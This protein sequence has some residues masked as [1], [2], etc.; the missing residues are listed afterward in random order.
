LPPAHADS[1][2]LIQN[3]GTG[4]QT[5]TGG[6][7]LLNSGLG[8]VAVTTP[9]NQTITANSGGV[10][11][12]TS[13]SGSTSVTAGGS[14]TIRAEFVEVLTG[15]GS[16][17]D[18]TLSA[19]GDQY[20]RTTN[21]NANGESLVVAALGS[22]TAKIESGASQLLEIGYPTMMQGFAGSGV[23]AI[24][25]ANGVDAAGNSL[26]QAVDQNVFSGSILVQ[27]PSGAGATSK[28]S[29]TNTQTISTLL[30][31]I[32]VFGGTG[33]NSLATIDPLIQ[34]ILVNGS[35]V[36]EGGSGPGANADASIVSSGSQTIFA[37]NG[38]ISLT[39]GQTTG[40]DAIISNLGAQ[41]GCSLLSFSCGQPQT[42]FA[43]GSI[44]LSQPLGSA[45]IEGGLS[46]NSTGAGAFLSADA[47]QQTLAN[48]DE[49]GFAF[50]ALAP[51]TEEPDLTRRTPICR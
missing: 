19:T 33:D 45:L 1:F 16:T 29:A 40:S 23:F 12:T 42:L 48:M 26:V 17:G 11:L 43:T 34:T 13:N 30:G 39:G 7:T 46:S 35:V 31:G 47:T 50:D 2:V 32:E 8:S 44:I 5:F 38:D 14:Q 15:A 9:G 37:T 51:G 25:Q 21:E 6:L 10:S 41:Q 3:M 22:G 18:A 27:G 28:L 36:L 4:N 20:I 24:G 49:F